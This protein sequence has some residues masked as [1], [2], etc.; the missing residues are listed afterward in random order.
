MAKAQCRFNG[1][2]LQH[3]FVDLGMS[4]LANAYLNLDQLNQAEKFYPLHAY[5]SED[6]FLVQ[7]E[8]FETPDNIFSDYAYFSSYSESWLRHAKTYTDLMVEKFGFNQNSQVIEIASNDGYLLQYFQEKNIPVLGIEP[9]ANIAKV[10][11]EKG[12]PCV[13]KFFGVQ[14]A[15]EL[16]LQGVQADLL[17]GN[18][19]LAHVPN[20]NDF[21]AG[22]KI[23]LKPNG[24]LTM[25]FP[26]VLQLIEQNQFDT[27]YHEHFSYFSFLTVEKIFAAHNL[28]LFDVEELPTH[29]G[30]LR[31]YAKHD[32]AAFPAISERVYQLKEKEFAAGLHKIETYITFGEKVKAT[33][34]KLLSF[35]LSAKAEGKTIVGYG[36][37]AKGNTL[38][39]Y[40]GIG[41]DFIDYTVDRNPHKQGL[42][43]PGTHIPICH[44]DTIQQT[45][46]DYVL[47]LPWN[48][49]EEI[50][51]QMAFIGE[52]GG[53]FVTPIPEVTII[54]SYA[55][56]LRLSV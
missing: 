10:A 2:P 26:H 1:Q 18:N 51:E 28:T 43:L 42:Y 38:L 48:L 4:P 14:T 45:K 37:P 16:V 30:S 17:L 46:P 7:L 6:T 44:P 9:A 41:T 11:E 49:K 3:T 56:Q 53:Q 34:R 54:P 22:M 20:L 39:N 21:I 12:I 50:I 31:I 15:K 36:A 40:C 47:I 29:G 52:W 5:V 32:D 55:R 8:Q 13:I 24:V 23:I 19:V 33:K 35:M 25:E 27:I